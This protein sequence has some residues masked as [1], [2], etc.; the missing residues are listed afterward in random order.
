MKRNS[1]SVI[2]LA[3]LLCSCFKKIPIHYDGTIVSRHGIPMQNTSF[4]VAFGKPGKAKN[5]GVF[6]AATDSSGRFVFNNTLRYNQTVNEI[7]VNAGDSG[8]FSA[9]PISVSQSDLSIV[10]R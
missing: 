8:S 1:Y 4:C 2:L 5:E 9:I 3:L 6:K 7:F 10:L